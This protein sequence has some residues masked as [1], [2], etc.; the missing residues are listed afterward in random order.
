MTAR[1]RYVLAAAVVAA[2]ALAYARVPR[3]ASPPAATTAPPATG[4]TGT[5][6]TR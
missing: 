5:G 1:N 3:E 6:T 2:P 4:T